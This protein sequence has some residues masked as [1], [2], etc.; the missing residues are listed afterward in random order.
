MPKTGGMIMLLAQKF[1]AQMFFIT[2]LPVKPMQILGRIIAGQAEH[3][4]TILLVMVKLM[5]KIEATWA[6]AM[7]GAV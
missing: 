7:D 5:Y 1:V 2:V 3:Y 6:A 4:L